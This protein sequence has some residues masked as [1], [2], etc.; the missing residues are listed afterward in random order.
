MSPI[1]PP[2]FRSATARV[3][4]TI[5]LIFLVTILGYAL[6]E[7]FRLR[8][9]LDAVPHVRRATDAAQ[10]KRPLTGAV[11]E[12]AWSRYFAASASGSP[13]TVGSFE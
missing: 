10:T 6:V 13:P 2:P 7:A 9:D 8:R 1:P 5:T 4:L 3:G 11:L 12:E